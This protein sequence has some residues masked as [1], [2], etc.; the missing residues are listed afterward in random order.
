MS[1]FALE[2]EGRKLSLKN[3]DTI[4]FWTLILIGS[5][6]FVYLVPYKN[7]KIIQKLQRESLQK[8]DTIIELLKKKN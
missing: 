6:L 2:K 8:L 3:M 7:I 1:K 5:A 4:L